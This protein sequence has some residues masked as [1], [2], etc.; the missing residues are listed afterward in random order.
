VFVLAAK[1]AGVMQ[2]EQLELIA[3]AAHLLL[4]LPLLDAG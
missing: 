2:L 4:P 3:C 1:P